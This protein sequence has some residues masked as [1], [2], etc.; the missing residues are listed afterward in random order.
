MNCSSSL[1]HF[2][3]A[4]NLGEALLEDGVNDAET[5]SNPIRLCLCISK[6]AAVGV[7]NNK[8]NRNENLSA[9]KCNERIWCCVRQLIAGLRESTVGL[10]F[11]GF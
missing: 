3:S 4:V 9:V 8:R 5:R 10:S 1:L 6:C 11:E 7:V 2:E